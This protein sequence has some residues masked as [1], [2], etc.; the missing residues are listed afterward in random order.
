M[1]N[2]RWDLLPG[3][4]SQVLINIAIFTLVLTIFGAGARAIIASPLIWNSL[5]SKHPAYEHEREVRL[6]ILGL[7]NK[8]MP[9]IT[10]RLRGSE[11]VPY[12]VHH[13]PIREPHNIVEIVVGPAALADTERSVRTM[14]DSFGVDLSIEISRSD[15]PYRAF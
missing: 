4:I 11:I 6:I 13:S 2:I 15:I 10:T 1:H 3:V 8:L 5:T 9:Y 7:R 14:L 12:I